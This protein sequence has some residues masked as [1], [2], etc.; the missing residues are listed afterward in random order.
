MFFFNPGHNIWQLKIFFQSGNHWV[1]VF[2]FPLKRGDLERH[3]RCL[4]D[5]Y[6]WGMHLVRAT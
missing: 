2:F 6:A 5:L 1:D 3:K 4:I